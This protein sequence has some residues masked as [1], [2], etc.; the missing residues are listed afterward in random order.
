MPKFSIIIR[1]KNEE[2]WIKHCLNMVFS[3]TI[4]DIEVIIV[5]NNSSDKT[6]EIA[7]TFPVEK[8]L[9]IDKFI[10]GKAL[11]DGVRESCGEFLVFL[12]AHCIPKSKNWLEMLFNGYLSEPNLAGVYGRQLPLSFTQDADKRDLMIVFGMDRK[13]QHKDYFFHNANSLVPRSIWNNYPFDEEVTNIEDRVWGKEVI[14]A[15]YKILYEPEASVYHYHGLHQNNK[16][17][18]VRGVVSI[19]EKVDGSIINELPN[20]LLPQSINV[21]SIIPI[22]EDIDDDPFKF[23]NAKRAI[24]KLRESKYI[25]NIYLKK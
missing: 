10:P 9:S 25:K 11:N 22:S 19:I 21:A 20:S 18:R 16:P 14:N 7:T 17:D 1:T 15:G 6:V 8:I 5:D 23:N 3:Q 4:T 2:S 13:I 24:D 12:S